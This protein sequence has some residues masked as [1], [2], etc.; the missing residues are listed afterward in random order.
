MSKNGNIVWMDLEMTGLDPLQDEIIEV[1]T[2]ITVKTL[3]ISL[4]AL[5]SS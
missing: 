3:I 2:L 1:A 5:K 4:K